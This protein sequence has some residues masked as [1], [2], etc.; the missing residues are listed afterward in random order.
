MPS[1]EPKDWTLL[2]IAFSRAKPLTPVQLQKSLFL[3]SK[4]MPAEIG[5]YF[6][7][8]DEYDYGPFCK[9]I[10]VD[11]EELRDEGLVAL[12]AN[13]RGDWRDYAAS[14]A[15][16][17]RASELSKLGPK[18][19][20]D[21]LASLVAWTSEQSFPQLVK[22]IYANYPEYRKNSIFVD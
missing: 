1:L 9:Q 8:F 13:P 6:Y 17:K 4:Q 11:A 18:R 21:H 14:Q 22:W 19:A 5:S 12:V 3:L 16:T 20:I 10:Y 7:S 15:G 2:A